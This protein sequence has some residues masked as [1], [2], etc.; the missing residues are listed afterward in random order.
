M[1]SFDSEAEINEV[2]Q[3]ARM[4]DA[5]LKDIVTTVRRLDTVVSNGETIEATDAVK[6]LA[7]N[8]KPKK[9]KK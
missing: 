5:E 2:I 7:K 9:N 3:Q 8:T 4:W 1:V 6:E